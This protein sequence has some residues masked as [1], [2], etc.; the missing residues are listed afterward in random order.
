MAAIFIGMQSLLDQKLESATFRS[1]PSLKASLRQWPLLAFIVVSF[2]AFVVLDLMG[3][4]PGVIDAIYL[5]GTA[6]VALIGLC[7]NNFVLGKDPVFRTFT[8]DQAGIT[9]Q[10]FKWSGYGRPQKGLSDWITPWD[11][12]SEVYLHDGSSDKPGNKGN[13]VIS[14][15]PAERGRVRAALP[16]LYE[17]TVSVKQNY[18]DTYNL[19]PKKGVGQHHLPDLFLTSRGNINFGGSQS[20]LFEIVSHH[21]AAQGIDMS[22]TLVEKLPK[23]DNGIVKAIKLSFGF[24]GVGVALLTVLFTLVSVI[25]GFVG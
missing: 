9:W 7:F 17:D 8:V 24:L 25:S 11:G 23:P 16:H 22:T 15:T 4:A 19:H 5:L 2:I 1:S 6:S 18:W 13:V 3:V 12:I 10:D 21:A 14:F 20:D